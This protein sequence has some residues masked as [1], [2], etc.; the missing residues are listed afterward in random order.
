[1]VPW[2]LFTDSLAHSLLDGCIFSLLV[3]IPQEA[4]HWQTK[5]DTVHW[6]LLL[7][8]AIYFAIYSQCPFPLLNKSPFDEKKSTKY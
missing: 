3:I 2:L 5:A 8:M 4:I 6:P 1:M 7:F